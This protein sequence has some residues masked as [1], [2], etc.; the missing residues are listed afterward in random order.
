MSVQ[1]EIDRIIQAVAEAHEKVLE[2]GGTTAVP[3]LVANLK[4]AIDSIPLGVKLPTLTTP[5][6]EVNLQK[7]YQM[8]DQEGNVVDGAM[9]DATFTLGA[10]LLTYEGKVRVRFSAEQGG[11]LAK[12]RTLDTDMRF[13][14]LNYGGYY[15][16][17][18]ERAIT[19]ARHG[20][21]VLGDIVMDHIPYNY[22]KVSGVT[23]RAGVVLAGSKFVDAEGNEVEGTMPNNGATS[24]TLDGLNSTSVSVPEGYTE[25]GEITFDD[26]ALAARI[27]AI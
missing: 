11:Y 19:L 14:T 20:E 16:P 15:T 5:G 18:E 24:G 25:G 23:A 9:P 8:I 6:A 22:K 26:T 7:G 4:T 2:K 17:D 1:T 21:V 3:Y 10:E 12:G 13:A 27:D